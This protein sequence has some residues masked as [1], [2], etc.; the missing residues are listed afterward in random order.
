M[1]GYS[2]DP[3]MVNY[4]AYGFKGALTKPFDLETLQG[5]ISRVMVTCPNDETGT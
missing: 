3:A 2:N 4:E 5:A 1:S